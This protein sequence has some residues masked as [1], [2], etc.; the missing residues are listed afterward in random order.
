[1]DVLKNRYIYL[2]VSGILFIISLFL[3]FIPKLNLGIDMTGGIQMDYT[4]KNQID[5]SEVKNELNLKKQDIK[6]NNKEIIN[7][8]NVYR[9]TGEKTV[10]VVVGFYPINDAKKL[11]ELKNQFR[12]NVL[13][14]LKKQDDSVDESKYINIGKSFGDYIRNTAFITLA[15]AIVAITFY[16]TFAFSGVVSGIS[17]ISFAAITIITLFHDVIISSGAYVFISMFYPE[18]KIDTFFITALLTILGYS[19]NDTIVVFDR[20]RSNLRQFGGKGKNLYE[21]INLSVKET[22]TRSIYTSLTLVFVLFTI[23]FFGPESIK[24]FILAMILGTLIGTYS[25]IFIASPI[26]YEVNKNKKLSKY[27]KVVVNPDD[28]IVV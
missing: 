2:G 26:L 27:K 9:I 14:I 10:S 25:S 1:M 28:K 20:I 24:G 7:N 16:V 23:F 19:I 11:D 4:Y 21:I 8:I 13:S 6:Y 22:L 17:V 12:S 18:F 5:I 3:L 15:L